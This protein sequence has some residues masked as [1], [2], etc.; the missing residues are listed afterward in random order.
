MPDQSFIIQSR[1][2]WS[3]EPAFIASMAAAAVGLGNL[4]RFPYIVGENGGGVFVIA[5]LLALFIVVLPIMMLEVAA[6][7]LTHGN[8]VAT[9]R[10]VNRLGSYY[11]WLVVTITIAI[12]SY[13]L[14]ITGWTLGYAIDASRGELR[15]FDQFT[16]GYN[17]FWYFLVII[18]LASIV[19]INGLKSIERLSKFLMPVLLA[20]M[21][22]LV[23]MASKTSGWEQT[24]NFFFQFDW[25]K[26][27]S[28]ELWVF[29]FGQAFYTLAIGQ[30]YLITYG[31]YI[32]RKTNLPRA[33]IIVAVFQTS[34]ALLAAW[35]IFPFVFS[36]GL[37]PEEGTQLAFATM[38]KVFAEMSA[39]WF[40]GIVFFVLFFAAAFTSTLAGLKVVV[41]AFA[42]EFGITNVKAVM[43]VALVM[44]I[45]GSASALSFTPMNLQI[46]GEPVLDMVD[47]I[48]G[49]NIIILSGIIGAALFCWFIPPTKI[50]SVLGTNSHWWEWR[51]YL[52]GRFLPIFM[53]ITFLMQY[54]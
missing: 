13:Y 45:I 51:I 50:H 7:R 21:I 44:L 52:V 2:Q 54:F 4:W 46:A 40:F 8:T 16:E 37:S 9:F 34:I 48:A 25:N 22:F 12:T 42:E 10:Q 49:G 3:S 47:R 33:C 38:P 27:T 29:A 5:Y 31:S 24:I 28:G 19:L 17:S 20:V 6:G 39:G 26:I 43:L 41:S 53:L 18:G 1:K 35:M 15:V 11:G 32:P 30:G 36:Q 14:V 23:V